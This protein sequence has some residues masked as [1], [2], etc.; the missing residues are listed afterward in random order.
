ME[1]E[2]AIALMSIGLELHRRQRLEERLRQ[3]IEGT[4][5]PVFRRKCE[6]GWMKLWGALCFIER[7]RLSGYT[8]VCMHYAKIGALL[9]LGCDRTTREHFKCLERLGVIRRGETRRPTRSHE[10]EELAAPYGWLRGCDYV[11]WSP[12][13]VEALT[14]EERENAELR[15][16]LRSYDAYARSRSL[17]VDE[18]RARFLLPRPKRLALPRHG[19]IL[20]RENYRRCRDESLGQYFEAKGERVPA[21]CQ[22]GRREPFFSPRAEAWPEFEIPEQSPNSPF[23]PARQS[24]PSNFKRPL[25]FLI[26]RSSTPPFSR[27]ARREK[28]TS[29][30]FSDDKDP[31]S[32]AKRGRDPRLLSEKEQN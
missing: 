19:A 20:A 29:T 14:A 1:D 7:V 23:F 30:V 15:G 6:R 17:D 32:L 4:N 22:Q 16:K 10:Y 21:W 13:T 27:E 3:A 25:D 5:D 24:L 12:V 31:R 18:N 11:T 8:G 2:A 28:M 26:S 9:G